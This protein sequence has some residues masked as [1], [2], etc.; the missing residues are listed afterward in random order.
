MLG[1]LSQYRT[2]SVRNP[3]LVILVGTAIRVTGLTFHVNVVSL[4]GTGKMK[5]TRDFFTDRKG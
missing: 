5:M 1:Y 3:I 4:C 2:I